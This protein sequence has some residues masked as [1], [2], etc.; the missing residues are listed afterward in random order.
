MMTP[1]KMNAM[2]II[3]E[4]YKEFIRDPSA[5]LG[6][7][8]GLFN[9]DNIFEWKCTILGPKDTFYSG[10]LFYLK[11]IFPNNY[12]HSKP[13]MVFL[14]PIY[15]LNVKYFVSQHQPL[16]HICVNTLNDWNDGDSVKKILPELFALLHKNN[17]LS[18]YDDTNNT[19]RKEFEN[20]PTLFAKKAKY[21][22]KKFASPYAKL[23]EYPN[24]WDFSYNE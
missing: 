7:T 24:G 3:T 13:E 16:G 6:I 17:P 23:K 12:P 9:E 21:F 10:G 4:E 20:N 18:P 8:V 22:T 14:T 19:R 1:E 11:I 2:K 15:H 5:S